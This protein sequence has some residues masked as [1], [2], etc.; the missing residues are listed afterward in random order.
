MFNLSVEEAEGRLLVL[1]SDISTSPVSGHAG[2]GVR[3]GVTERMV[4]LDSAVDG[5][6]VLAAR[7]SEIGIR[8]LRNRHDVHEAGREPSIRLETGS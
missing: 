7:E 6:R 1:V 3:G 5:V 4:V 8:E 2:T